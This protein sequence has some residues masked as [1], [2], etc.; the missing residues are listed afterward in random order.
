MR[1]AK[2]EASLR[3][4][5]ALPGY[6]FDMLRF[7]RKG[8][9]GPW[10]PAAGTFPGWPKE[11]KSITLLDPCC[12]SGHFL[13]EALTVLAA[14]R[15]SHEQ[16]AP[17]EAVTAVLRD[18]LHGLEIDG[19][20]VQ[21]AAF[22]VALSAWRI[23]G[24]QTLPQPHIA[25]VG[26]PPPLPNE[27][28]VALAE[29]DAELEYALNAL[30]DLFANAPVLGSLI[31]VAG[32]NI[33]ES[34]QMQKIGNLLDSLIRRYKTHTPEQIEGA[35]SARGMM[36]ATGIL[37]RKFTI[38]STNVPY[39][40]IQ[41]H[42]EAMLL[43]ID[44]HFPV[45]KHDLA[46]AFLERIKRWLEPSGASATVSLGEW[47]YL[48]PYTE[49]RREFLQRHSP[50]L[51]CRLGW[52]AFSYP[53][54]ANPALV[55]DSN[56]KSSDDS[57]SLIDCSDSKDFISNKL[58]VS[59]VPILATDSKIVLN[60]PDSRFVA[61]QSD[62]EP[63]LEQVAESRSGLHAGD[64]LQ[65]FAQFWEIGQLGQTWEPVQTAASSTTHF[66][67]RDKI[68]KWEQESGSL[69][70]LAESVKHLNH[71]AQNWRAGKPFWGKSG[72]IVGLMGSAACSIY[73][74]E[75]FDSN[76]SAIV[77]KRKEDL[78][79]IWAF[80]ESGEF[81][82]LV[83]QIDN[84]LKLAPRTL[85]KIPFDR[86]YWESVASEK[87]S[88]GLPE[89]YSDDATQW[90]FHGHPRNCLKGMEL[91]VALARLAGYRWPAEGDPDMR[92]SAEARDR[93]AMAATLPEADADGVLPILAVAGDRPLADRLRDYLNIAIPGWDEA[94]LVRE[95]DE[96]IDKRVGKDLSLEAWLRDRA[97]R[98]HCALFQSRP[99]LWQVW[100]GQKDGFSAFLH[101][102]RLDHA[103]L[104]KLTYTLLGA[105]IAR[106]KAEND[107]RRVEAAMILQKK[108]E[109]I[110]EGEAPYDIF[111]RWKSLAQQPIGWNP[112]LDDG[113][114]LNIRPWVEAGV[115]KEAN[116]KG[117]KWGVDRGKDV[118]SAPWFN[119]DKGER[120]NDRHITL[121]DKHAAREA[122]AAKVGK[123]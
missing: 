107:E 42:D 34:E 50:K 5:C 53:I 95:A 114:R 85:L 22:A 76:S 38:V 60:N 2:D 115:L 109:A 39:L 108:L 68:I 46:T 120:N 121:A 30:H 112:D 3:T 18:N 13:T 89:P 12:G 31:E 32:G 119:L 48:G 28:F 94:T 83:R 26:A 20:C 118:T 55:V 104:Q 117:I 70:R 47:L 67:G 62:G 41:K 75:I 105:W 113:V 78:P 72:I 51:I 79:A 80:C 111:V 29:G 87:F 102:H 27:E 45:A 58:S 92:L 16:L 86:E 97:F 106:R 15:Q 110:L 49:Y 8:E 21:I 4:A 17:S 123:A 122:A 14:L 9:D 69:F 37:F 23:G 81:S 64:M 65:F 116:P 52:N 61:R 99:F 43:Y 44:D 33:F 88:H 103:A 36:D 93:I 73:T 56:L 90:T 1:T 96:Q 91:H 40:G 6:Y 71:A 66:S 77:P 59:E 11:P 82:R 7:V 25:W 54:R 101:Y 57:F 84:S 10:H 74:G 98:Q 63:L 19:R 100:D 35:I 24:W